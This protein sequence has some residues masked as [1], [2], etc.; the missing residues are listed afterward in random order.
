MRYIQYWMNW[1][2]GGRVELD[3]NASASWIRTWAQAYKWAIFTHEN[4]FLGDFESINIVHTKICIALKIYNPVNSSRSKWITGCWIAIHP[5]KIYCNVVIHSF[6]TPHAQE[7]SFFFCWAVSNLQGVILTV[8]S[9]IFITTSK[10]MIR[11]SHISINMSWI[12]GKLHGITELEIN[13]LR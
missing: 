3:L 12:N 9:V 5:I 6:F 1:G 10:Y 4:Q 7:W 13:F 8:I 2:G 11:L